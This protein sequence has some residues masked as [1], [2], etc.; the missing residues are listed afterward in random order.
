M[1]LKKDLLAIQERCLHNQPST[2]I[3]KVN[4]GKDIVYVFGTCGG[5]EKKVSTDLIPEQQIR[6]RP[7]PRR[8]G[9]TISQQKM[10]EYAWRISHGDEQF[11]TMIESES[12]WNSRAVEILA[13]GSSGDGLGLCQVNKR[14]WPEIHGDQQFR[15]DWTYQVRTCWKL[16]KSG[17]TFYGHNRNNDEI[18]SRFWWPSHEKI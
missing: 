12:R 9:A 6:L 2:L 16:W 10:I 15:S 4:G 3:Y 17:V 14:Y 13:D 1:V 18:I 11:I 7:A 5:Y 8:V